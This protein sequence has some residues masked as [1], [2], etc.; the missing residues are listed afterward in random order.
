LAQDHA[1]NPA[2]PKFVLNE[3]DSAVFAK[4]AKGLLGIDPLL[5]I[6]QAILINRNALWISL[7]KHFV[8]IPT[9]F[10]AETLALMEA[11]SFCS[12]SLAGK[13][14]SGQQELA[15]C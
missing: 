4:T 6:T 2:A 10:R 5:R 12:A 9:H 8:K 15:P 14:Y 3:K 13:R 1:S 7:N 11:A